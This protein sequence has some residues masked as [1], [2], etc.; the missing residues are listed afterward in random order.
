HAIVDLKVFR[1]PIEKL[2][3]SSLAR[4][5]VLLVEN[6]DSV[7]GAAGVLHL[8][9]APVLAPYEWMGLPLPF[10]GAGHQPPLRRSGVLKCRTGAILAFFGSTAAMWRVGLSPP[11]GPPTCIDFISVFCRSLDLPMFQPTGAVLRPCPLSRRRRTAALR[12][13]LRH[14]AAKSSA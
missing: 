9:R 10:V 4:P 11:S 1:Q 5:Q 2:L 8:T 3:E 7:C 14:R 12:A 6:H 13:R